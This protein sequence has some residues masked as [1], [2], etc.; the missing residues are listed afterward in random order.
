MSRQGLNAEAAVLGC[1]VTNPQAYWRVAD[2]LTAADFADP[3]LARLYALI[4]ERANAKQPL[5]FD[6]VTIAEVDRDLGG[7]ALDLANSDGWR[8]ANVRAYAELVVRGAV[9]RKVKLAGQ[10]IA[11]L[12]GDDVLGQAQQLLGACL[13]RHTGEVKHVREYLRASVAELQRR[14]DSKERMTGIPTSLP[15]LDDLTSGLQPADLIV[16][17]ARPS[18]GKTALAIQ[19][20]VNACRHGK[21][22]MLF[23]QEMSGV[24]IADRIQA[25]IAQVNAMGMKRPE[26][27]DTADFGF[28]M[29]AASEIAELPLYIDETPAL[30]LDAL[31]ARA[32]QKH[33]TEGL[34]FIAIDYFQ[35]MTPPKASTRNEAMA[36]VSGGLKALA[37][38]LNV[39][40][41]LLSQLNRDG[42]GQRPGMGNLR[43][44]GALEQDADLVMFLHRPNPEEREDVMLIL[45]KQRDGET[46]EIYLH[47]NYR[48]QR[49]TQAP[50][51]HEEQTEKKA[52]GFGG[53]RRARTSNAGGWN[54]YND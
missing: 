49:F 21:R 1:C 14:V 7:L 42:E 27:F 32:R 37:K 3:R 30:T 40:V 19:I 51:F 17:A 31:G 39:P 47:A 43:D 9:T 54:G 2:L 20:L 22:S 34:D 41:L 10:Q 46:G 38:E 16:L 50:M 24:K 53:M 13:P 12:D 11:R 44:T 18:V 48:H 36:M 26:L 28:L 5:P 8:Q 33:A 25:H 15:E 45:A 52:R 6:A 29:N 35:L 4:R 23:S